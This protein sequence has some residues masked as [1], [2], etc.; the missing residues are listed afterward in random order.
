[1]LPRAGAMTADDSGDHVQSGFPDVL[2]HPARQPSSATLEPSPGA[3]Q[4]A[5]RTCSERYPDHTQAVD[6]IR[7][8]NI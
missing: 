8:S 4:K 3:I 5:P 1:M 7:S 6:R 2:S